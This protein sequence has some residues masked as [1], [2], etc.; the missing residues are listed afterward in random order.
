[1]ID[2]IIKREGKWRQNDQLS[3]SRIK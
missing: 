3:K 2:E 1:V